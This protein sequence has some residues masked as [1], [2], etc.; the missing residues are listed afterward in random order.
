MHGNFNKLLADALGIAR[1]KKTIEGNVIVFGVQD[2][3]I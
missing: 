3:T 1:N 2:Q